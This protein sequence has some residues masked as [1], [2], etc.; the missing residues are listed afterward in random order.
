MFL[1]PE[2]DP[3]RTGRGWHAASPTRRDPL[4]DR[5]A[6]NVRPRTALV[7]AVCIGIVLGGVP[8]AGGGERVRHWIG[9][10]EAADGT[11]E[12]FD[13]RSGET[14][15]P[16]GANLLMKVRE[17]DHVASGLFRP[18]DWS[19]AAIDRELGRMA[20]LGFNTVRVF[21]DLCQVDCISS[22]RGTIRSVYARNIAAF[23]RMARDRDLV[24]VLASNDVPDRGYSDRLPC[25]SP[26]GGYRNSLWLAPEG[27]DL[28]EEY[29]TEVVRALQRQRAPLEHVI[30][31]L[32]QEQWVLA[33]VEPLSLASGTVTTAD[34]G[35]YDMADPTDEEAMVVS[36]VR[37]AARRVRAAIRRL[38]PGALVTMGFFARFPGDDRVVPVPGMLE[39]SALDL[40]DLHL[41]PGVGHTLEEHVERLGLTRAVTKPVVMGEY[42]AFRF[43]YPSA[44]FGAYELARWQADSCAYGFEGWLIWLWAARDEEVYGAREEGAAIADL[45]SPDS[46]PD[47]CDASDVPENV[48]PRGTATASAWLPQEPPANAIDG[49][50]ETQWGAG[51]FAPQWIQVDLGSV[52]SVR[53]IDLLVAQFPEG[54]T[55]HRLLLAGADGVFATVERFRRS[56]AQGDVL[57]FRPDVPVEARFV[58]VETASSPSWVAWSE[59]QVWA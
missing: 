58:R 11:R 47:P 7:L 27:H 9:V 44:R 10:R 48:A 55:S 32:Q 22:P 39:S 56:T 3:A 13:R 42:G 6:P 1:G 45:L 30:Y 28:L 57:T 51:A 43:A 52:R 2:T 29:W 36:N 38:D 50:A 23:L 21:I 19:P 20:A 4:R 37:V 33:D 41:Y 54:E 34:G 8:P 40:V 35:T 25:C 5:L 59:I 15:V 12:L 49:L 24:V 18:R 16:R 46:R 26:F 53:E 17:G 31:E 14:F